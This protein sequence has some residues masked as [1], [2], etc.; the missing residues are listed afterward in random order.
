[1]RNV[2]M[3]M[4]FAA[5]GGA[6]LAPGTAAQDIRRGVGEWDPESGLGNHRAVVRAESLTVP[7]TLAGRVSKTRP[8]VVTAEFSAAARAV[9]ALIP[10]RRPDHEPEKKAVVVVDAATGARITNV[11]VLS[12]SRELGD[13]IFE[14]KTVPGDY[15]V[16]YM[17]YKSEGR[18]NYPNVRYD[19]PEATAG[20]GW[21]AAIGLPPGKPATLRPDALPRAAVVEIQSADEFSA[22]TPMEVT[23]TAAEKNALLR[24]HPDSPYFL[25]PEDRRLPIRMT[26]DIP[27]RWVLAGPAAP[28]K[29]EAARGEYFTFQVG[30]WAARAAVDAAAVKVGDF[31]RSSP[32]GSDSA[33]AVPASAATCFNTCGTGWDGA[34]FTRTVSVE[35]GKV[36]AL[37]CG[38]QVS[39]DTLSGVYEGTVTVVP[40]NLPPQSVTVS[41]RVNDDVLADGGDGDP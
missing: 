25:F 13:I 31:R 35:S 3:I 39:R 37:W 4:A 38:L 32:A 40:K 26:D 34:N 16:Y 12:V 8:A 10:W 28:L 7:G 33:A 27:L 22:F 2:L 19:P 41:L 15:Y 24:A 5:L 9:R 36:Q 20:P 1:M 29:G 23:A 11:V 14:P 18:K 17:P 6:A 21:L 30:L